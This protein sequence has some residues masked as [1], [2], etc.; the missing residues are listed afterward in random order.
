MALSASV[1]DSIT[2]VN[3]IVTDKSTQV[4]FPLTDSTTV[5]DMPV[6]DHSNKPPAAFSFTVTASMPREIKEKALVS[7]VLGTRGSF[8]PLPLLNYYLSWECH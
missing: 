8:L 6:Y 2:P 5:T 7:I 4:L 3:F 1:T